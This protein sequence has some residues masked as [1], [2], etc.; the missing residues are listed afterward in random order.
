MNQEPQPRQNGLTMPVGEYLRQG[1]QAV[2]WPMIVL[3][4]VGAGLLMPLSLLQSTLAI[5][6][7]VIPVGIGLLIART[8]KGFYGL[9]GF[10]TGVIGALTSTLLLWILIFVTG[11]SSLV[12]NLDPTSVSP[13]NTFLTAS[14]FISFSLIAFCTFGAT[15]S[16]RMEE[17][18][19]DLRAQTA[20]RGGSLERAGAVREPGDIR[21]FTLAQLGWYVNNLFKKKGF[22]FRDYKFVDKDRFVDLW[23]EY[24]EQEWHVRCAISD[25][26]TPGT[27]E[28]LVQEM[29][30]EGITKGIVVASTEFTPAAMKSVKD[31]PVVLIDGLTL[32][33]ISK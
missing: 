21:G 3:Y 18:N 12:A 32:Y 15:T 5:V 30:R 7:G 8:A 33:D 9:Y 26:V 27:I 1:F 14:G 31:K 17:R 29:K 10:L 2:R 24:Q 19:R 11:N 23:Y 22:T 16:G 13:M 6:A 28:S 20:A 25:K 4:G